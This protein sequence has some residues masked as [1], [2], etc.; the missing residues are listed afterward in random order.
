MRHL[1]LFLEERSA[2]VMLEGLLPRI[3]PSSVTYQ[4]VVF[5]GKQDLER[6]IEK[7]LRGWQRPCTAFLVLRDQDLGDCLTIKQGLVEKARK[8]G[9]PQ[10]TVRIACRELESWYFGDLAAVESGLGIAN[11]I[12]HSSTRKYRTPDNISNP[13]SELEKITGN[14]YQKVSGSRAIGIHLSIADNTSSSFKAFLQG[15]EKAVQQL[16][17]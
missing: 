11:L 14:Q 12:R 9:K 1:V 4:C 8:A 7:R 6:Q 13:A 2:E 16:D 17:A 5:E 3:L 10:T 15:I